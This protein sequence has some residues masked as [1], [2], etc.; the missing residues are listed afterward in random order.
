[1]G[2]FSF[3]FSSSWKWSKLVWFLLAKSLVFWKVLHNRLS[4]DKDVQKKEVMM[5]SMC[6][7]ARITRKTLGIW[8]FS[9]FFLYF[10]LWN[11]IDN[12]FFLRLLTP[13]LVSFL[14]SVGSPLVKHINLLILFFLMIDLEDEESS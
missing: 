12:V 6:T 1:M 7:C 10:F 13:R 2:N 11:W 14:D 3:I 9:M 5:F 4:T 8:F